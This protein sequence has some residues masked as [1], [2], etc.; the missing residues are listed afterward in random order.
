MRASLPQGALALGLA[1]RLFALCLQAGEFLVLLRILATQALL[2]A[3]QGFERFG[4]H[5]LDMRCE[6][7]GADAFVRF[8][9]KQSR[10]GAVAGQSESATFEAGDALQAP[11][12][13]GE[14]VYELFFEHTDGREGGEEAIHMGAVSLDILRR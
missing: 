14:S 1:G 7:D 2:L 9:G 5:I 12:Q 6:E 10:V 8:V 3:V 13:V 4:R 11:L